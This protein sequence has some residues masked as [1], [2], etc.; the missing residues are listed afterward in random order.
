[1]RTQMTLKVCT[2]GFHLDEELI[3]NLAGRP[4]LHFQVSFDGT[5]ATHNAI[6]VQSR[7]DAFTQ[8]DRNFRLLADAGIAV[9]LNTVIQRHNVG[10]LLDTYRHFRGVPYLFHGFGI[11]EE[12][13]WNFDSN[14]FLPE[15]I[16]PLAR[17]LEQLLAESRTDA[18]H[19]G[20]DQEMIQHIRGRAGGAGEQG[21]SFPLHAGYGCTVPWSIVIVDQRGDVFPCFH[22]EWGDRSLF[23]IRGR[24]LGDALFSREYIER[25]RARVQID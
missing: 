12:G 4:R 18:K 19:V 2:N 20:I 13:S 1:G 15:Q 6:R 8:S 3:Q 25:S 24:S 11:V 14:D 9:S 17:E 22:T 16:E 5:G 23:S 10:N 7:Y 21:P